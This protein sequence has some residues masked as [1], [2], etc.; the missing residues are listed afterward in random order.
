MFLTLISPSFSH[1]EDNKQHT[2]LEHV[3]P[4]SFKK[5]IHHILLE[6][7]LPQMSKE[8]KVCHVNSVSF[9][10]KRKCP[11]SEYKIQHTDDIK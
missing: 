5:T 7:F 2:E 4:Y 3:I 9:A 1:T 10:I 8:Q 11:L 6:E